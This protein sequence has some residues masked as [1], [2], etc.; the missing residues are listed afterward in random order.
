MLRGRAG[1]WAAGLAGCL[2]VL[3][4]SVAKGQTVVAESQT[5]SNNGWYTEGDFIPTHRIRFTVTNPLDIAL[6]DQPIVVQRAQLPFEDIPERWVAI[7]DPRL[8][9]NHEPTKAELQ[10]MSGYSKRKETNGHGLELQLDDLDK[11]G[12]WDEIFFLSDL[13]PHETRD[14]YVYFD[15]YERGLYPHEVHAAVA[16][17]G[18]HTVPF[19]ESKIM[20]WKLWYPHDL[21]LHGKRKP[22]LTAYTEYSTNLS[23]YYMPWEDGTDIMMVAKTFGAGGMCVFED[24]NDPENPARAFYSP[25]KDMGPVKDTRFSFD[26]IAN[27]PLRAITKVSTRNWNSGKGFY[28]VDQYYTVIANKSYCMVRV[29]FKKFMPP[30]SDAQFGAGIR[31]IMMEYKSV[32]HDG[33]VISMGKNV[34]ARIPD[35]NIG[36]SALVVPWEGIALVVKDKYRPSY[37]AINNWDGNHLFRIPR[38]SDLSYEYMAVGGWSFGEV[39]NNEE[40]FVKYVNTEGLKYNNPPGVKIGAYEVKAK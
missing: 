28:E 3:S 4:F 38:T 26:V 13:G 14:F 20:G 8:P 6:K 7:V 2:L 39:N 16:N 17:Y 23:G 34:L 18:R 35:E 24:P 27:G 37:V 31:K 40:A 33:T 32:H 19:M 22:M 9:G 21:D 29:D 36:D 12:I 11:D 15:H 5:A 1:G 10:K 25:T 30:G